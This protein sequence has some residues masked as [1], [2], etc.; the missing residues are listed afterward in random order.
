M[1]SETFAVLGEHSNTNQNVPKW[2]E[3]IRKER[4]GGWRK[5]TKIWKL[6]K[7]HTKRP[8]RTKAM[9]E[10]SKKKKKKNKK[11]DIRKSGKR[12]RITKRERKLDFRKN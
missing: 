3:R 10:D 5:K 11:K 1:Y 6:K 7:G 8:E 12:E 2:L 9:S 4:K